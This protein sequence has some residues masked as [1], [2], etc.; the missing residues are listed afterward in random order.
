MVP[1]FLEQIK[2]GGPVTVTHPEMR[3]YFM[4]IPEAVQLVLHAAAQAEAGATY[5]LDMGEQVK[6]LDMARDLIRLSGFVPDEEIAIEFIGL[7]PGE[8]LYE[9]L[10]GRDEE[11][12]AVGNRKN[13][14]GDEPHAAASGSAR[15]DSADRR[16]SGRVAAAMRCWLDCAS[17]PDC[18]PPTDIPRPATDRAGGVVAVHRRRHRE[19]RRRRCIRLAQP[20]PQCGSSRLHRSRVRNLPERVTTEFLGAAAVPVRR[21]RAGAAGCIP[22]DFGDFDPIAAPGRAR[23][24]I[25]RRAPCIRPGHSPA[26]LLPARPALSRS[27]TMSIAETAQRSR[28]RARRGCAL[29]R[30]LGRPRLWLRLS[31]GVLAAGGGGGGGRRRRADREPFPFGS[32]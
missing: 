21:M 31:V 2:Q 28:Q 26:R 1:R 27:Q 20:C 5:V 29:R 9:E 23:S 32:R 13:P 19:R 6:L 7:R 15:S 18:R 25:A 22:L 16:R 30:D 8:K 12:G 3:R 17:S 10:V 14:A 4:L 24:G 11:V